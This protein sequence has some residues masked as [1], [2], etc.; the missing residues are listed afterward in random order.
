ME[1]PTPNSTQIVFNMNFPDE[2]LKH[3]AKRTPGSYS[4]RRKSA[5]DD[6]RRV[7]DEDS[8][9][10][11]SSAPSES[12]ASD[13]P[14]LTE[15]GNGH[16]L[17]VKTRTGRKFNTIVKSPVSE[18][19]PVLITVA[20]WG[21]PTMN[22]R[23]NSSDQVV[24]PNLF[25]TAP[26]SG[27]T[28][29][30]IKRV[31]SENLCLSGTSIRPS[32]PN[33]S[34]ASTP[35]QPNIRTPTNHNQAIHIERPN[36]APNASTNKL[37]INI[38]PAGNLSPFVNETKHGDSRDDA[39]ARRDRR[40]SFAS[41]KLMGFDLDEDSHEKLMSVDDDS[42]DSEPQNSPIESIH[43]NRRPSLDRARS[44]HLEVRTVRSISRPLSASGYRTHRD[45]N[46]PAANLIQEVLEGSMTDYDFACK[47]ENMS[48]E[49]RRVI[50]QD[51]VGHFKVRPVPAF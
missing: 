24:S 17:N 3:S 39:V 51:L 50:I 6:V 14:S 45:E 48:S 32:T 12:K 37:S 13:K 23:Y 40:P 42:H 31:S 20:G 21:Y 35:H 30:S 46:S 43:R 22:R 1:A 11:R 5:R 16:D 18:Q 47:L 27:P 19:K 15:T 7:R 38:H 4:E 41:T 9:T 28:P 44:G 33:R 49:V 8:P 34:V 29:P 10:R 36:S 25:R 26:Y 2:I